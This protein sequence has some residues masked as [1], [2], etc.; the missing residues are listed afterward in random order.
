MVTTE[1]SIHIEHPFSTK[2]VQREPHKSNNHGKATI[3]APPI[4]ENN[5][6]RQKR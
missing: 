4:P 5:A 6:K 3:S 2:T 1:L